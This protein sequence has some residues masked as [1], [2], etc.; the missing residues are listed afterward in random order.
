[1][2]AFRAFR[3][4]RGWKYWVPALA[5]FSGLR[6]MLQTARAMPPSTG[7]VAPTT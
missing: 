5:G 7:M 6:E 4:F 1:M 2:L 3:E